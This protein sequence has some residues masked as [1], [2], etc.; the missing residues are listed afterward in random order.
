MGLTGPAPKPAE[1]RARRNGDGL[2]ATQVELDPNAR[3]KAPPLPNSQRFSRETRRWYKTWKDSAQA[4][5]FTP[6][7][8]QRLHMLAPLVDSYFADPTPAK[9]AEISR[10]EGKLGATPEDRLRLRWRL[11][12]ARS[13]E[14]RAAADAVEPQRNAARPRRGD[15]RLHAV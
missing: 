3:V 8:W 11:D 5:Q 10:S 7:D 14:D 13:D 6:T 2:G 15:P 1:K 9:F 12:R 4:Q